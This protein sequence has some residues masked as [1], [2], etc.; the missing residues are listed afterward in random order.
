MKIRDLFEGMVKRSDPYIS[1]ERSGPRPASK[2]TAPKKTNPQIASLAK[3]ANVPLEQVQALWDEVKAGVDVKAPGAYAMISAKVQKKLGLREAT[4][5]KA[6]KIVTV[7]FPISGTFPLTKPEH[8]DL[9]SL[10]ADPDSLDQ[11]GRD[12][13]D[14]DEDVEID[15]DGT[16]GVDV[17]KSKAMKLIRGFNR[18]IDEFSEEI[19]DRFEQDPWSFV[20]EDEYGDASLGHV[21]SANFGEATLTKPDGK[22]MK[23]YYTIVYALRDV[24]LLDAEYAEKIASTKD[25]E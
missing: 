12:D 2:T 4:E 25:A 9:H 22:I 10:H 24:G 7:Y 6:D 5:A 21:Y 19:P 17:P 14:E 8:L 11:D 1:G 20:D 3:R 13:D 16:Y 23:N 15:L 18:M